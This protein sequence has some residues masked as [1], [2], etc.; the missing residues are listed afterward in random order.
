MTGK[1]V[2]L[3]EIINY[4]QSLQRQVEVKIFKFCLPKSLL[5]NFNVNLICDWILLFHGVIF[6]VS[7]NEVGKCESKNGF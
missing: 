6:A 7:F 3:D 1:A 4:V 5:F 2:M